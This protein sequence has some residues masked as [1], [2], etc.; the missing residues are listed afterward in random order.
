AE[1]RWARHRLADLREQAG[2]G[3]PRTRKIAL[4]LREPYTGR[5]LEAR[6]AV[7]IDP[8]DALRMIL[9]GPGGTTA[10]DL[11]VRGDLYRFSVPAIGLLRRGDARA[12]P[13]GA[14]GL[15]VEF[16]RWW[17]LRPMQ[18]ELL[19]YVRDGA[20]ERFLLRDGDAVVRISV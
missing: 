1:W 16:L 4:S 17:M 2:A 14:R 18:G 9:I 3:G 12:S 10:L 15:P 20:T 6:G 11:W 19:W 7:A 5:T 13:A 8:P